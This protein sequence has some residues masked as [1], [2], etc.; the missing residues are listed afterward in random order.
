MAANGT[1]VPIN[2]TADGST[3]TIKPKSNM[4]SGTTET[5][6][7]ASTLK[8]SDGAPATATDFTFVTEGH[9]YVAPPQANN[10]ISYFSFS[11]NMNDEVGT[12]TPAAAAVKDLAF[13][14]DRFGIAGL[15]GDFNGSTSLVEIP[16]GEQFV[17]NNSFTFS[18]WL[19]AN[20][21]K[22]GQFVLGLGAWTGFYMELAPDWTWLR[23]TNQLAE[24]GGLSSTEDNLFYGNGVTGANGG[25][26]GWTFQSTV[27]GTVGATYFQDKWAHVVS[28]YDATTKLATI[29]ING[30]KVKEQDFNLWSETSPERTATGV[31]FVGNLTGGGNTLA[32]G[33]IQGSQNRIIADSWADP[34]NLYSNHFK[35]Q[36]DDIRIFKVALTAAEVSTLYN[37]EAV[38]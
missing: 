33:F 1:A 12:H 24:A 34:A 6:T 11:G 38:K 27:S 3:V 28:T 29:Y 18:I 19:K 32:L 5:V 2:I 31:T 26:Q 36:M 23:F 25:W 13:T 20:G 4:T 8:G 14:T 10:Q 35:G 22:N 21:A 17:T 9:A 15:S 7:I 30:E 37:A 16:N